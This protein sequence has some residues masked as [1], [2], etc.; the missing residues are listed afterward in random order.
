MHYSYFNKMIV[1]QNLSKFNKHTDLKKEKT[2]AVSIC[3]KD[4]CRATNLN[5]AAQG[6]ENC[7]EI[8]FRKANVD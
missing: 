2:D 3:K 4:I 7:N 1:A 8:Y 5:I 6:F